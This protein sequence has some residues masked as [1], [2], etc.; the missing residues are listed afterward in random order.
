[1]G[2]GNF[3]CALSSCPL[4]AWALAGAIWSQVTTKAGKIGLW[5]LMS[6][7]LGRTQAWSSARKMLLGTAHL[8]WI[9]VVL[10][11]GSL[12]V[13]TMQ[14]AKVYGGQLPQQ[15]PSALPAGV[16][17]L[18]G[19][20]NRFLVLVFCAWVIATAWQA[21]RRRVQNSESRP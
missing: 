20:A 11:I 14:F 18:D 21:I 12:A 16:S 7:S 8:T 4:G 10:L 3:Q 6:V 19:W 1:M 15:A 5:L 17:G 13:M 2:D 9:S